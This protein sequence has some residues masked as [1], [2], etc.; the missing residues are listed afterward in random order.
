[1][2][3]VGDKAAALVLGVVKAFGKRVELA[4]ELAE[5]VRAGYRE[6]V[7]IVPAGD[8]AR[9]LKWREA[10][11]NATTALNGM[12]QELADCILWVIIMQVSFSSLTTLRV[13]SSTFSAVP[14]SR[15][16]VCSSSSR[17]FGGTIVAMTSVSA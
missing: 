10:V 14:G 12:E 9:T 8:D 3:S 1:M 2:R 4:P 5:L 6:P 7:L 13:S 15:A 17:S 11:L 16:A